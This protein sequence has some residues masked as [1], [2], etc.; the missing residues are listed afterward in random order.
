M[1]RR[2]CGPRRSRKLCESHEF[3]LCID[4]TRAW[5]HFRRT[6]T[7]LRPEAFPVAF[8]HGCHIRVMGFLTGELFGLVERGGAGQGGGSA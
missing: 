3:R 7:P 5:G 2:R 1:M 8:E 4:V 6:G